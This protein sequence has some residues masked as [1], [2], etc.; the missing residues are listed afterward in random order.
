[1]SRT[2]R[3]MCKPCSRFFGLRAGNEF[4]VISPGDLDEA[5][6]VALAEATHKVEFVFQMIQQLVVEAQ[7]VGVLDI[8]PPIL[9][10]AFKDLAGGMMVFHDAKK[11]A[12]VPMPFAYGIISGGI[13]GCQ[14]AFVP[15]MVASMTRGIHSAFFFTFCGIFLTWFLSQIATSLQNPFSRTAKTLDSE[16]MQREL[17][18]QLLQLQKQSLMCSPKITQMRRVRR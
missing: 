12:C 17:N 11:L 4:E 10:Q 18:H 1:M 5:T 3:C 7:K 15:L 2:L 8:A 14:A 13:L 16:K 9:G 6:E